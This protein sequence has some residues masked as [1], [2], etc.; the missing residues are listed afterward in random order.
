MRMNQSENRKNFECFQVD[1]NSEM[2]KWQKIEKKN[3]TN[4]FQ[5]SSV[6]KPSFK[7][8]KTTKLFQCVIKNIFSKW[9]KSTCNRIRYIFTAKIKMLRINMIQNKFNT[10]GKQYSE[11]NQKHENYK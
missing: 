3:Q 11:T 10:N 2:R 5:I 8:V 9:R 4:G 7:L 6:A 1:L